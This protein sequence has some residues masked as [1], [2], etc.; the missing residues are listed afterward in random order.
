MNYFAVVAAAAATYV[1]GALWYSPLLFAK[2]WLKAHGYSNEKIKE[3]Q[4]GAGK[5]YAG[6][7]FC[8]WVMA[9][10]LAMLLS[11]AGMHGVQSGVHLGA[12]CWL[13]FAATTG[14]AANLF[15]DKPISAFVV[16]SGY[17]LVSL[18]IMGA[19]LGAWS[20]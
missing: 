9:Y 11:L 14:L 10:V 4:K 5:A 17:Q 19:I 7:F 2:A 1:L 18:L 12:L 3:M 8:W 13:G 16:D 6:S 15:S 20:P